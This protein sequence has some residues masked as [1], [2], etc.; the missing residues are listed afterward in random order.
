[1]KILPA[2]CSQYA[3]DKCIQIDFVAIAASCLDEHPAATEVDL[4]SFAT[5]LTDFDNASATYCPCGK[6]P[7]HVTYC[8][9][10][11]SKPCI[12]AVLYFSFQRK[13]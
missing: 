5:G 4:A 3:A 6:N 7:L 8:F 11:G 13:R 9:T 12:S 1:M 2:V 10:L